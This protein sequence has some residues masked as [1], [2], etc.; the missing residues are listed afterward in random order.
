MN[1]SLVNV[2]IL[3]KEKLPQGWPEGTSL[4]LDPENVYIYADLKAETLDLLRTIQSSAKSLSQQNFN[5]IKLINTDDYIWGYESSFAFHQGFRR[6]NKV[7]ELLYT[8][9]L[10]DDENFLKTIA[11]IDWTRNVIDLPADILTPDTYETYLN[12]LTQIVG[13]KISITKVT[14]ADISTE[15]YP[16]L[17]TVG[18]GS[19]NPPALYI[20][21]YQPRGA[22]NDVFVGL[23]GKGITF[24]SGGYS[25][26]PSSYM[27]SMHTDMGGSATIAG[28]L[29][30]LA[31]DDFPKHVRAYLCCA[32][33][34]VSGNSMK[35]GD[36]IRYPNGTSV[37]IDNTDAEGR[38][39]LADGLLQASSEAKYVLDAATLTGAA[40]TAI[41][42]DFNA[43]LGLNR[44]LTT[45]FLEAATSV[46][47]YAWEL[48]LFKFHLG[49]VKSEL[50]D[51]TNSAG[52]PGASTAAAFLEYFVKNPNNWIHID[53][54]A[55]YQ[56]EANSTYNIGAK[57]HGIRSIAQYV[58]DL[59][60]NENEGA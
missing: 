31:L 24:D 19:A 11:I 21:D 13:D 15:T 46:N 29:A 2:G 45:K 37:V 59:L 8:P 49:A 1:K 32:E 48:P 50:A 55:S 47:E 7:Q 60:K 5:N 57:G 20:L 12:S 40:K 53:L 33:N 42:R 25:L 34:M 27:K 23:V 30:L 18:K 58:K 51:L 38:L 39:V 56:K 54:S 22:E 26:K 3:S 36:V 28:A 41:G 17:A 14:G 10:I 52:E 9:D 35:I 4:V 43:V 16:G 44:K 6:L